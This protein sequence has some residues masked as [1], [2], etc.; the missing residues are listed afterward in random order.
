MTAPLNVSNSVNIIKEDITTQSKISLI[1][2]DIINSVYMDNS[3]SDN[4]N[5]SVKTIKL[6]PNI[7]NKQNT[8]EYFMKKIYPIT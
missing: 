8:F 1:N 7:P 2:S 5:K 4:T 3:I 6:I